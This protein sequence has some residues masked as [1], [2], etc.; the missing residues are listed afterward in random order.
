MNALANKT[1]TAKLNK[2]LIN[3]SSKQLHKSFKPTFYNL[4]LY[5]SNQRRAELGYNRWDVY[6]GPEGYE[7]VYI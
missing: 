1:S 3:I 6:A 5:I 4:R 7:K 2:T